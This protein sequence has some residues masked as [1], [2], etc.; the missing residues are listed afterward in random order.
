MSYSWTAPE[1]G[2]YE[3]S[4]SL[5]VNGET[6]HTNTVIKHLNKGDV[7]SGQKFPDSKLGNLFETNKVVRVL[8]IDSMFF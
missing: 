5:L 3:V 2:T 4:Y 6:E 7:I 8:R 1:S